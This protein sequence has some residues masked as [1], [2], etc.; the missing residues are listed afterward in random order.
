MEYKDYYAILGVSR[1][2]TDKEIKQA[3]RRLARKY[4]PDVNP[5]N[6]EAEEKFKEISEAYEV[7]SDKEKREKYDRFGQY[8][9]QAGRP[10]GTGGFTIEDLGG[11]DF[12]FGTGGPGGFTDF[13]EMLF[14]PRGTTR[15]RGPVKGQ[16]IE[17]QI[18]VSLQEA[19]TGTTKTFTISTV[20]G[21][22]PKRLEVKIP[23]GV[24]DGSRIRLA[25]EGAPSPTGG[26]N[27][28]LYLIVKILPDPVWERKG[29][30][31]YRDITVPF[32]VAALGGEVEVP[33]MRGKVSMK[34]P[35]GTQSGQTFR[36]SGLGMPRLGDHGRGDMYA[37][38]KIS[39]PKTLTPRQRELMQE[40]AKSLEGQ[41]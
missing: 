16:D 41:W 20:P 18:E 40:L 38:V 5:G 23:A 2:A 24:R 28:D 32:T 21:Q 12:G 39:V 10:G 37:R 19:Y 34:I 27:G 31:L 13:F 35:P 30:D 3:Y 8:W 33:T 9:Q 15:T 25:G 6:K 11:F 7:L 4:H 1:D 17:A 29:D 26:P 22:P 36:L 14:G